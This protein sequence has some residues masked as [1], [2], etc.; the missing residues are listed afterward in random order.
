MIVP[1]KDA[2]GLS[3]G[4]ILHHTLMLLGLPSELID[5]HLLS[6]GNTIHSEEEREVMESHTPQYIFVLDQGSR[7]GPPVIDGEHNA[8]IID[9]HHAADEDF[10]KNS[11]HVTAC[12]SPPVATSSLLTYL[13]C[14]PLHGKVSEMCN[15][16][17]VVSCTSKIGSA[18]FRLSLQWRSKCD[19]L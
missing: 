2:D 17:C 18:L 14:E 1:D 8:L 19:L 10:P 12:D 3:S 13:L 6:K 16:L 15:W 7:S 5:V 4:V 11:L 9:H